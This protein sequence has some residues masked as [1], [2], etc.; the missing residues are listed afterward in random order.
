MVKPYR[1]LFTNTSGVLA[2]GI[3]MFNFHQN[4]KMVSYDICSQN[5]D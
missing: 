4:L 5:I 3:A 1:F 2:D